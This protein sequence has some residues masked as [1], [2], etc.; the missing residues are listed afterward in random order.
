MP[1]LSALA[2]A[3]TEASTAGDPAGGRLAVTRG[4]LTARVLLTGELVAEEAELLVVPNANIWPVQIRWLAEDGIEVREGEKVVEFDNSQLAANLQEMRAQAIQAKNRVTSLEAQAAAAESLAALELE[5]RRAAAEK[6]R[7]E[8]EVPDGVLA[9]RTQEKRRLDLRRAELAAAEAETK[10]ETTR[11]AKA[12][13]IEV[14]RLALGK[15]RVQLARQEKRLDLLTL[16]AARDGILILENYQREARPLRV[17]DGVYPGSVLGRLPDL[18]SMIVEARLFDVDDGQVAAGMNV[19]AVLDAFPDVTFGGRVRE[20]DQIADQ[21]SSRSLRRFFRVKI[22]LDRV[23]VDRMRPGMSV[24]LVIEAR[25][26]GV[27]LV[28][29]R[30]LDWGEAAPAAAAEDLPEAARQAEGPRALLADGS[31]AAVTLGAC[32]ASTCVVDGGLEEGAALRALAPGALA[33][34]APA[35]VAPA[36][37]SEGRG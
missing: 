17:G 4:D 10:L 21:A 12:S 28:P 22:D 26:R 19:A 6:A 7:L 15:T 35:P 36:R 11:R 23:D 1:A 29:R 2:C 24:K 14:E 31:W 33:P 18:E 20:I 8:A 13:E 5:Q 27:L 32:D 37:G 16:A 9:A 3:G 25:H 34:G 30:C